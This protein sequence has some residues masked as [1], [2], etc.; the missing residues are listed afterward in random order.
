MKSRKTDKS[1]VEE[2]RGL[3]RLDKY[4]PW[5]LIHEISSKG[6]SWRI[7]GSKT[8]RIHHLLSTLEKRVFLY[9]DAHP[10]VIDIREQYPIPLKDTLTIASKLNIRHGHFMN[11]PMIMTTD[12]LVDL[13]DRQIAIFVKP[14]NKINRRVLEKFQIEKNYWASRNVQLIFCTKHEIDQLKLN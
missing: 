4:I 7:L 14:I 8:R 12:F 1:R 10:N 9:L 3:G 13:P 6:I 11:V 2:G 5:I